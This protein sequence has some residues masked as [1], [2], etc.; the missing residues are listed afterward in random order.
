MIKPILSIIVLSYNTSKI[1]VDCLKS[2][3]TDKNLEFDLSKNNSDEKIPTELIVIDNISPDDSVTQIKKIK[4]PMIFIEN[5]TNPGFGK[6][7]NQAIKLARGNYILMINSDVVILHSAISQAVIWLSSHPEAVACTAQLLNPDQTIQMSGGYFPNFINM[8]TWCLG[9]DDI[10]FVNSLIKPFHPHT[11]SFYT[12][13]RFYLT[14]HRQDWVT[15]A[16]MLFRANQ[17]K[18]INGFDP[19][20]FMYGEEMELFYRLHQTYPHLQVWY[21]VGPQIIHIGRASAPNKKLPYTQE[22][23][24]IIT[25]YQKHHPSQ[26]PVIKILLLINKILRQT[27]YKVFHPDV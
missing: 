12:H 11:P 13:D 21:L 8:T 17:L 15:G 6:T 7:N 16:F 10:P 14:D 9:I 24:G 25:F 1:T 27:V 20:Y 19:D 2:V 26:L 4:Q 5:K 3:Y 18:K 22:H 23:E